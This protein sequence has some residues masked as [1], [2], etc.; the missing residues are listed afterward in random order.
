MFNKAVFRYR[1]T[2]KVVPLSKEKRASSG[3]G[4]VIIPSDIDRED[5]IKGVYSTGYCM[6]ITDNNH[7]VR[8]VALPDHIIHSIRFPASPEERG[9]LVAWVSIPKTQQLV[10]VGVLQ[11]P[12][13]SSP[14]R[15]RMDVVERRNKVAK[16]TRVISAD[17]KSYTISVSST[18]QDA[19]GFGIK[20]QGPEKT[21]SISFNLD[22]TASIKS[23]DAL[24]IF[25][26]NTIT[27]KMGSK[28]DEISTLTVSKEGTLTYLDRYQNDLQINEQGFHIENSNESLITLF[29]DLL[30][31]YMQTKTIDNKPLHPDS[32]QAAVDLMKR[33]PTLFN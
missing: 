30:Q 31:M 28:E 5:Y 26:E 27:V 18:E 33:F 4:W 8:E 23:D 13:K 22:G 24:N 14:Y 7:P 32:M 1:E 20:I 25:A 11:E 10:V 21:T 2:G 16:V 9:S 6:I 3:M 12:A 29:Q 17:D 19:G 15:E